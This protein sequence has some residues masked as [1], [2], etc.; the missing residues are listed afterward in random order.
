MVTSTYHGAH[1]YAITDIS[2]HPEDELFVSVSRDKSALVW[3][4]RQVLPAT[5]LLS[6][7]PYHLT[8][9]NWRDSSKNLDLIQIGDAKGDLFQVDRRVPDKIVSRVSLFDRPVRKIG[10]CGEKWLVCGNSTELRTVNWSETDAVETVV[11]GEDLIR[12]FLVADDQKT[13]QVLCMNGDQLWGEVK[14]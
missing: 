3:D 14:G 2:A 4:H 11:S 12:D 6:D 9:C 13:V 7:H 8:C 1:S 10:K 5:A